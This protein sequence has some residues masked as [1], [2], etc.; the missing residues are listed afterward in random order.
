VGI[1]YFSQRGG[2]STIP[3]PIKASSVKGLQKLMKALNLRHHGCVVYMGQPLWV[4]K[5]SA[6]IA[7]YYVNQTLED[8]LNEVKDADS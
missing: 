7:W 8:Q 3:S 4:E 5:E 2:I 6:W 1:S